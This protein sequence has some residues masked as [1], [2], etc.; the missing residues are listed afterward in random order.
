MANPLHDVIIGNAAAA[1]GC[2]EGIRQHDRKKQNY[3]HI[4]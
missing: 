2:V 1:V 4:G 3:H